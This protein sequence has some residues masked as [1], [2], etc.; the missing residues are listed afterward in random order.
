MTRGEF[1]LA[2]FAFTAA[3]LIF[4][5]KFLASLRRPDVSVGR[6]LLAGPMLFANPTRYFRD[7]HSTAPWRML[8]WFLLFL[9]VVELLAET[10]RG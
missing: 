5:L 7:G 8:F 10:Y 3:V 2:A 1:S 9:V 4:Q 6:F